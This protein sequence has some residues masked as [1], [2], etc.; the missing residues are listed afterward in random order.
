MFEHCDW[1]TLPDGV[2]V[3]FRGIAI[4][5]IFVL[6]DAAATGNL[7]SALTAETGDLNLR[8]YQLEAA[9]GST[10]IASGGRCVA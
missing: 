3:V 4:Q 8:P 5:P 6:G 1:R 10:N 7:L 2:A 9:R